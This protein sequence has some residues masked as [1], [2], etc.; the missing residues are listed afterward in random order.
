MPD[1]QAEKRRMASRL[2]KKKIVR[3]GRVEE[4]TKKE[5]RETH[6]LEYCPTAFRLLHIRALVPGREAPASLRRSNM[7]THSGK[8]KDKFHELVNIAAAAL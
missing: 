3:I 6:A 2:K 8:R 1:G 5:Y 7:V 4:W